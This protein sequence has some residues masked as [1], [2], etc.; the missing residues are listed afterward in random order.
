MAKSFSPNSTPSS[1][2]KWPGKIV[3]GRFDIS[4]RSIERNS[5]ELF[6]CASS[7]DGM[8]KNII[9][10]MLLVIASWLVRLV[11]KKEKATLP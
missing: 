7:T 1:N 4:G 6:F 8:K 10:P 3:V 2:W 5:N 9:A 11:F